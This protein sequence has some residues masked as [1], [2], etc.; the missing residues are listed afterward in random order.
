MIGRRTR[1]TRRL[2]RDDDDVDEVDDR[3][4]SGSAASG[5]SDL[6]RYLCPPDRPVTEVLTDDVGVVD[7]GRRS[8]VNGHR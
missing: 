4:P 1:A 5:S 7:A 6:R 8:L 2:A 3:F